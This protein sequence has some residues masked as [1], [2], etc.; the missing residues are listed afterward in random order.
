MYYLVLDRDRG[1]DYKCEA[2]QP[3]GAAGKYARELGI[4]MDELDDIEVFVIGTDENGNPMSF[5]P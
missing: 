5:T 1:I 2:A 4:E 3:E